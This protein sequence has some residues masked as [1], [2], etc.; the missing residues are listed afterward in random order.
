[1]HKWHNIILKKEDI[2]I[3]Y[4]FIAYFVPT[5]KFYTFS[6]MEC[7]FWS[8]NVVSML[9]FNISPEQ[10]FFGAPVLFLFDHCFSYNKPTHIFLSSHYAQWCLPFA[11]SVPIHCVHLNIHRRKLCLFIFCR[12]VDSIVKRCK[13]CLWLAWTVPC[14]HPWRIW[15]SMN[16]TATGITTTP[17]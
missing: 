12:Y 1:M 17:L 2:E 15:P 11:W 6:S 7:I 16:T 8:R 9:P 5:L 14:V 13:P 4:Q 3:K 10:S